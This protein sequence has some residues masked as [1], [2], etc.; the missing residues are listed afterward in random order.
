[1]LAAIVT[2]PLSMGLGAL[3]LAPFGLQFAT[4]GVL[5]GL[6]AAAFLGLVAIVMGARGVAI[7]APRSLVSFMIASV[8]ADLFLDARWLPSREPEMVMAAIFL[9]LALAGAFQLAFG[10]AHLSP[11]GQVHPDA[12][13]GGIPERRRRPSSCCRSSRCCW[14]WRSGRRWRNGRKPWRRSGRSRS[15]WPR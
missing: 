14:G 10:L 6:Y 1:M 4:F 13:H 15:W 12:G 3:A 9:L 2:L 11:G 7:Y 8:A 5:A